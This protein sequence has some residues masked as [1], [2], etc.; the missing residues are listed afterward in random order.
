MAKKIKRAATHTFGWI[1]IALG[2]VGLVL[3]IIPGVLL[4]AIGLYLL[5]SSSEKV[6]ARIYRIL[7]KTPRI[8]KVMHSFEVR[9]D[10]LFGK[11]A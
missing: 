2:V 10:R 5:S 6:K 4:V 11:I 8:K 1:A 7:S 9:L 3:P